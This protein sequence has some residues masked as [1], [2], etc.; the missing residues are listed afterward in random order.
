MC[1]IEAISASGT[2]KVKV[3]I[4]ESLI[5]SAIGKAATK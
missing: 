5:G 1:F 4:T 2:D 3:P